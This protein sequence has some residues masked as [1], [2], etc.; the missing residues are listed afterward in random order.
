METREFWCKTGDDPEVG[1][2]SLVAGMRF[3]YIPSV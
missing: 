2:D 3:G 1:S